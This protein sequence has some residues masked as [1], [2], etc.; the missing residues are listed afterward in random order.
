MEYLY[1]LDCSAPGIYE[2]PMEKDEE[3]E[4]VL[5][6]HNLN[7]ACCSW[8]VTDSKLDIDVLEY[9]RIKK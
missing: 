3:I 2:I 4:D 5:E 7:D 6:A 8:M 9:K 1:V